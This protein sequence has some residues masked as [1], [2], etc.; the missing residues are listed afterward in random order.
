MQFYN[1]KFAFAAVILLFAFDPSAACSNPDV[2][3]KYYTTK[4]ATVVTNIAYVNEFSVKCK[5]GSLT[6]LYA[7]ING[8]ILP[9]SSIGADKYQV[10]NNFIGLL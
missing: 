9:V 4:D 8:N 2:T 3:S 1:V 7:D 6:N 5:T 10:L